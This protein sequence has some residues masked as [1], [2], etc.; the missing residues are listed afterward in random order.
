MKRL[1]VRL[2][3]RENPHE[4]TPGLRESECLAC[5][6]LRQSC[7]AR[8]QRRLDTRPHWV[9]R[10]NPS[11]ERRIETWRLRSGPPGEHLHH[12]GF[13]RDSSYRG[14]RLEPDG[15]PVW[16]LAA[17]LAEQ[18]ASTCRLRHMGGRDRRNDRGD[19]CDLRFR[20][21]RTVVLALPAH[22]ESGMARLSPDPCPSRFPG[23][24][25]PSPM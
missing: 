24:S 14:H 16:R 9:L 8:E 17:T 18:P 15:I 25:S 6:L 10:T 13:H 3:L 4:K 22:S 11:Y 19:H 2:N 21:S 5:R 23:F 12:S 7:S 20:I 1:S